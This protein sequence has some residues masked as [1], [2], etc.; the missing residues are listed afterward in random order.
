M[1]H[2]RIP[3]R[4][5]A[6]GV[7]VKGGV[8]FHH[9]V[10]L[11]YVAD[12]GGVEE[13]GGVRILFS[14]DGRLLQP[15]VT[16]LAG[17]RGKLPVH[18]VGARL[19]RVLRARLAGIDAHVHVIGPA[20]EL[21]VELGVLDVG[22]FHGHNRIRHRI[23]HQCP[24][25]GAV[26]GKDVAIGL[27]EG[28]LAETG[29]PGGVV[30]RM[31]V[32]LAADVLVDAP[33]VRRLPADALR[34][35]GADMAM[36]AGVGKLQRVNHAECLTLWDSQ[37]TGVLIHIAVQLRVIGDGD[38]GDAGEPLI[39]LAAGRHHLKAEPLSLFQHVHLLQHVGVEALVTVIQPVPIHLEL[40]LIPGHQLHVIPFAIVRDDEERFPAIPG[41][42]QAFPLAIVE[43]GSIRRERHTHRANRRRRDITE[44]RRAFMQRQTD[45][46]GK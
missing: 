24:E 38:R 4:A 16:H 21:G 8:P 41:P 5:E 45:T 2:G 11:L 19:Q 15:G 42:A 46:T 26:F 20:A 31:L 32:Q 39:R 22:G 9:L 37:V 14:E 13:E 10:E 44:R 40:R 30:M 27:A 1:P 33:R 35:G 18:R 23:T 6:E 29:V 36:H 34:A 17:N 43:V 25:A 12:A 28:G 7:F 3:Q